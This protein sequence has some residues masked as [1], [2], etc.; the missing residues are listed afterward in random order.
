MNQIGGCYDKE[1]SIITYSIGTI[2]SLLLLKKKN[3]SLK[4]SGIFFLTVTQMQMIE[5]LI[6]NHNKCD[7]YNIQISSIGSLIHH[8]EP[9]ILFLAIK[10]Y[11]KNLTEAQRKLLNI[12]IGFYIIGLGGYSY[13][14]Y[15]LDCTEVTPESNSHLEWKW[16]HKKY[17]KH[18]YVLF[19]TTLILSTFVGLEKPYNIY[20]SVLLLGSY[21]YSLYKY[22]S[23]KA[24]GTI[25]CWLAVFIPLILLFIDYVNDKKLIKN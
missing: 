9:I 22:K 13:N 1:T 23:N 18:F 20:V 14:A 7:N 21:I 12:L 10:Y 2:T 5:F 19:V 24:V 15:P 6:W 4:I 3:P 25:W 11:N 8:F 17:Y 16:N